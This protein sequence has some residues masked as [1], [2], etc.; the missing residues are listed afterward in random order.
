MSKTTKAE[1]GRMGYLAALPKML[2]YNREREAAARTKYA[3][4]ICP[5]CGAEIPYEKREKQFCN[6]S[7]SAAFNNS[8][9]IRPRMCVG[10]G[11]PFTRRH[12][13]AACSQRCDKE[14]KYRGYIQRWLNGEI[15]GGSWAAV[16]NPVRKW[17]IET[18]GEQCSICGWAE[19]HPVSKRIPLQVDHIDGDPYKH[20]PNNLRLLC[21]NCH[22]LTPNFGGLNRGK[23]RK[24]RYAKRPPHADE[25]QEVEH[26][27]GMETDVGSMPTVGPLS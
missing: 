11:L 5:A 10:C 23:G 7:C 18:H 6:H 8:K 1:A 4:K 25:A 26:L 19:V 16:A 27:L 17:L 3:T 13:A 22:S 24:E 12:V 14:A 9:R 15:P 20:R 21:P 2:A